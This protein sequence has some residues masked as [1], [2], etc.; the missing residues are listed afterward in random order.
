MTNMNIASDLESIE[1]HEGL[2][3]GNVKLVQDHFERADLDSI[4]VVSG[5]EEFGEARFMNVRESFL[6][7][8]RL[9]G[10][11]EEGAQ[12]MRLITEFLAEKRLQLFGEHSRY[13]TTTDELDDEADVVVELTDLLDESLHAAT[14][15]RNLGLTPERCSTLAQQGFETEKALT[16]FRAETADAAKP[17]VTTRAPAHKRGL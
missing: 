9:E 1:F 13:V 2:R 15:L 8:L 10:M 17:G 7:G 14:L 5:E 4:R 12:R 6:W 3:M 16:L 11:S